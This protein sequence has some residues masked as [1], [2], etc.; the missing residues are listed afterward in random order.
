MRK[1]F[2][3][4]AITSALA[5]IIGAYTGYHDT[6]YLNERLRDENEQLS[7]R[8]Y[9]IQQWHSVE[10]PQFA[11]LPPNELV[12]A[13]LSQ[14]SSAH[15]LDEL[16]KTAEKSRPPSSTLPRPIRVAS[17]DLDDSIRVGPDLPGPGESDKLTR[18]EREYWTKVQQLRPVVWAYQRSLARATVATATEFGF[19]V[20]FTLCCAAAL[21]NYVVRP[22]ALVLWALAMR[23]LNDIS[24]AIRG[25]Y[26]AG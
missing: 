21:F 26:G 4:A 25:K 16:V 11:H 17:V 20:L 23:A 2:A 1:Y 9:E 15:Q 19:S 13:L 12:E 18:A 7:R 5:A 14:Y 10:L 6:I 22:V 8:I 24:N 3:F